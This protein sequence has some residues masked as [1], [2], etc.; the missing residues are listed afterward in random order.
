[1]SGLYDPGTEIRLSVRFE[2]DGAETDPTSVSLKVRAPDGT[3]TTYSYPAQVQRSATGRYYLDV[4][5]SAAGT[6][7]YK[8]T[9][10][11]AVAVQAEGSFRVREQVIP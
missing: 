2:R 7:H 8:W 9:A 3:V 5:P 11:G 10:T 6:W 4:T 1:M